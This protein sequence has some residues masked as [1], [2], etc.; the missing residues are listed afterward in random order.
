MTVPREPSR[1]E[2]ASLAWM[3]MHDFVLGNDR[4]PQLRDTLGLGRGSGRVKTLLSLTHGPLSLGALA[5]IIGADAPYATLIV[6]ELQARGLV[7]RTYDPDDRRRKLVALTAAGED[8]ANRAQEVICQPPQPLLD[9]LSKPELAHLT[10]LLG[11]LGH[12]D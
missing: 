3:R 4:N 5:E 2:L 8:A 12:T 7:S 1:H 6:N 10:D 11:R 9:A